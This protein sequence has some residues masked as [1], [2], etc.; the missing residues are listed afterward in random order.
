MIKAIIDF[1]LLFVLKAADNLLST[2]KT[3]LL[4][5]HRPILASISVVLSQLIFYFLIDAASDGPLAV[6]IIA[7]ASGV[8]TYLAV[9]ISNKFSKDRLFVNV[10]L[11]DDKEAMVALRDYLKAHKITNLTTDGYKKN[12]EKTLAITAYAD[13]R[14]Q[15]KLID[16]YLEQ[17]KMKYKR[18]VQK[19]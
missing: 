13:T 19:K 18:I 5:K 7:A 1:V 11:S 17:S 4:Q 15:S 9:L 2:G 8:G 10:I 12:W 3:L 16:A 6:Y 14:E